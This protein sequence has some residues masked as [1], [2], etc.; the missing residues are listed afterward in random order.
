[1]VHNLPALI[2]FLFGESFFAKL[3]QKKGKAVRTSSVSSSP[4]YF[5]LLID[6]KSEKRFETRLLLTK[7]LFQG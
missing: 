3:A 7:I 4:S 2:N 5:N 1:M 6:L